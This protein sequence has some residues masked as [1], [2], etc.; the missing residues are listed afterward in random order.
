MHVEPHHTPDA[1]RA[2]IRAEKRAR[3]VRRLQAVLAARDGETADAIGA[4]V[5]LSDRAVHRWVGRYN[6]SGVAGLTDKPGRGRKKPLTPA[7]E[8]TFKARIRAGAT[9][10]DGVCTLRGEDVRTILKAEFGV[11]RRLQA[12]YDLLHALGFSCLRPRP[13]HPKADPATQEAFRK[14]RPRRSPKSPPP[15]RAKPSRSGS[16]TRPDSARRGP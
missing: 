3:M 5:Q 10:A 6:A 9:A 2:L 13:Q 11:V 4:R 14:K 12:T 8:E 1:L 15:T 16:R 7:Q